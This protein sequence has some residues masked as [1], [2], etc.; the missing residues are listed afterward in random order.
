MKLDDLKYVEGGPVSKRWDDFAS[1]IMEK[2]IPAS[3]GIIGNSLE[4]GNEDYF[5]WIRERNETGYF[6]F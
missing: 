5:E 6:E 2:K 4:L 1:L 3:I